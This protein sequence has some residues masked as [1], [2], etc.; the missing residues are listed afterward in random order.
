MIS[1]NR[2]PNLL[3]TDRRKEIYNNIFQDFLNKKNFKIYSRNTSLGAAFAERFSKSMRNLLKK[4]VFE[5]TDANGIDIS[6]KITKQYNNRILSSTRLTPIQGSSK[7]NEGLVYKNLLDKRTKIKPRFQVNDLVRTADLKKTF[8]KLDTT[9]C[10]TA[11]HMTIKL[12]KLLLILFRV[13][14]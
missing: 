13:M 12:Q 6:P 14:A 2:K 10:I 5:K 9:N 7:N 4:P 8:S 3:E 1:S 11:L